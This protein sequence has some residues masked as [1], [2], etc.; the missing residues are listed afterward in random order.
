MGKRDSLAHPTT[1]LW[2]GQDR[3]LGPRCEA[4]WPQNYRIVSKRIEF[5]EETSTRSERAA[6]EFLEEVDRAVEVQSPDRW[7]V[8]AP[9]TRRYLLRRFPFAMVDREFPSFIQP[10][11][12]AHGRRR[13]GY[14]K[15]RT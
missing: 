11:G 8:G 10:V 6:S 2:Y 12:A 5:H 9:N 13:A 3:S 1:G 15:K 4:R 7:P 14:G